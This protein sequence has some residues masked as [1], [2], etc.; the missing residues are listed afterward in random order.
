MWRR[1]KLAECLLVISIGVL[2]GYA[3]L[4]VLVIIDW[5]IGR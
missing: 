4:G 2:F 3:T 5:L 1:T